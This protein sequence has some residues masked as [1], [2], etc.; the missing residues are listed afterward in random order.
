M[1]PITLKQL[2]SFRAVAEEENFVRAAKRLR[3]SQSAISSQ[4]QTLE[5]QLGV[6]LFHRTTRSV[7][8]TASGT[9]LLSVA[10]SVLSRL[11]NAVVDL[12]AEEALQQGRLIVA[13][14]PSCAS[15]LLPDLLR[16]YQTRYPNVT[17]EVR[18]AYAVGM[19]E[20]LRREEAD[21]AIGPIDRGEAEFT[22]RKLQDDPYEVIMAPDYH[23]AGRRAIAF[24]DIV[25]EP[26]IV[27]ERE[28]AIY[29]AM[30]RLFAEQGR[31]WRPKFELSHHQS[32]FG[33]VAAGLGVT[34]MPASALPPDAAG[35]FHVAHLVEPAQSRELGL[36][37]VKGNTLSPAAEAFST[38]AADRQA[39]TAK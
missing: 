13:C 33:L 29:E 3:R 1:L 10:G 38:L 37:F 12:R 16:D 24:R 14:T 7:R 5:K 4:I 28:S 36:I 39:K 20:M 19:Y 15:N 35:R 25:D 8:V 22:S 9:R 2:E 26:H 18:E 21:I 31:A 27:I 6:A 17:L 30:G 34:V 11:E 23:L 32:L